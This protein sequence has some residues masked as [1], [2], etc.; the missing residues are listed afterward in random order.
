MRRPLPSAVLAVLAVIGLVAALPVVAVGPSVQAPGQFGATAGLTV[1]PVFEGWYPNP[2]G[3]VSLSFGYFNRNRDEVLD[4]AVGPDNLIEPGAPNQGQPTRFE[5]GRHWGV[6]AVTVPG[7]APDLEV[8]W[9]LAVRGERFRIP[10]HQ[11]RSWRIDALEGEAGSGNTPPVLRFSETGPE[12]AGPRG[13]T[14]GL[15]AA[16]AG[17]PFDLT[18]WARDDGRPSGSVV[19]SGRQAMTVS[20]TWFA[21]QG[22]GEVIFSAPTARVPVAGGSATTTVTIAEP[23][24]YILRVRANDASGVS[25]AG[26]AQCCWTNGFVKV[27]VGR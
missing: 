15:P 4:V 27:T 6:F 18:V 16:T 12:G 19:S 11:K 14:T 7:D 23:G 5:P 17:V 3:T 25:G 8:A 10:G 22:P 21:H 2:D 26:H 1:T 24:E 13:V 9:T 20:L